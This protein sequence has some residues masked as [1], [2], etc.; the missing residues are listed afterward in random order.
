MPAPATI[1]ARTA[2]TIAYV[3]SLL[4]ASLDTNIV[5]VMLPT[6]S[7]EFSAPL[8][9]VKWTVIGYVLALAIT[10]P[11]AAWLSGR[12]GIKRVYLLALGLFVLASACCGAAQN[13][14]ELVVTRFAQG[15]A[16]GL[17]GPVATTMLYRTYPQSERARMTRLLLMPIALGPALAPPLGG[18]LVSHVSWR[19]AFLV[20]A[21]V[22]LITAAAVLVGLPADRG[23]RGQRLAPANFLSAAVGLSGAMYLISEGAEAGWDSPVIIILSCVTVA[24]LALFVRIEFRSAHPMLDLPLLRDRLFRYSNLST[25]FQTMTFLGGMLYLTPLLLQQVDGRSPLAAGLVMA[26]VP[27]GVVTSSQTV[28]RA[29]DRIGPQPLVV[30]GESLLAL[31]LIAVSRFGAATPIWAF[32]GAMYFAGLS[33]GMGMVGLQASMFAHIPKESISGGATLLNVNRQVATALGVSI[34]TVVLTAGGPG[35]D[36]T[37]Q[38]YHLAYLI[39]AACAACAALAGLVIPRRLD[40]GGDPAAPAKAL[41][42]GAIPEPDTI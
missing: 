27:A 8:T 19:V 1:S 4:L 13:L 32:C 26:V 34:A 15:A 14:P 16:G 42:A 5:N 35:S 3:T 6:L 20:N 24:A 17:I 10:M 33:N 22:G 37:S 38:P 41:V 2:V 7:R 21:P 30:V 29:F 40:A 31:D 12:F 28:G 9:S 36:F 11:V 25:L 23:G 18:L 39:T